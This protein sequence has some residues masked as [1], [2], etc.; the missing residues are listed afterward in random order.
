MINRLLIKLVFAVDGRSKFV[1]PLREGYSSNGIVLTNSICSAGELLEISMSYAVGLVQQ[2]V[3]V[4]TDSYMRS[5]I[6]YFEMTRARPS[7]SA[8]LMI[9]TW[10]RLSFHTTDCG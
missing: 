8:T 7:F 4:V 5:P 1:P 10:S 6:D 9:G 2:A 3:N